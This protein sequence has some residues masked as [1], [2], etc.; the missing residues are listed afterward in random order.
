[1]IKNRFKAI[2][3]GIFSIVSVVFLNSVYHLFT[4]G[5]FL[6]NS[7]RK[8]LAATSEPGIKGPSPASVGRD[9]P[10]AAAQQLALIAYK[11]QCNSQENFETQAAKIQISGVFCGHTGTAE[12]GEF[13]VENSTTR[14]TATVLK[15]LQA[16]SFSTDVIPLEIG[17]NKVVMQFG[18]KNGKSFPVELTINRKQ[19]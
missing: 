7:A 19:N 15:D 6:T 1:M 13:K 17:T 16:K 12:A 2:E 10:A 11:T 8:P 3:L 18:Y 9:K 5:R 4:D 14:F